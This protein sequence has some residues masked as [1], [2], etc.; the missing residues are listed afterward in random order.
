MP[1]QPAGP[2]P[3]ITEATVQFVVRLFAA[4]VCLVLLL[5]VGVLCFRVALDG[6]SAITNQITQ[7]LA[8][9]V[10]WLSGA[11]VAAIVGTKGIAAFLASK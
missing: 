6:N 10:P 5:I 9:I 2:M 3:D 4:T 11:L 1:P 8:G 7:Q